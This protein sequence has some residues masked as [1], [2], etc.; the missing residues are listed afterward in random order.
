MVILIF[1]SFFQFAK[2]SVH[3]QSVQT[4]ETSLWDFETEENWQLIRAANNSIT[5]IGSFEYDNTTALSNG[6]SGKLF[7][8]FSSGGLH[9]QIKNTIDHME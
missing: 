7:G 1:P 5:P 8:D 6:H 2:S 3:A 4:T 9:V